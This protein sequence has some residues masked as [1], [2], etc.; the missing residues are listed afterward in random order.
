[1]NKPLILFL[2]LII[3]F[4]CNTKQDN[5]VSNT[6]A[7]V[8]QDT[9][10]PMQS[11]ILADLPDSLQPKTIYLDKMPAPKV[12]QAGKAETKPLAVLQN[13]KG[14]PILD[15][16]GKPFI[17]GEGGK[18][19]F[20]TFTTDNG[21]ALDATSCSVMDKTGNL[22]FGTYG[23]GVSKYNGKSFTNYSTAQG[24]ANNVVFSIL[25]DK[26]GNLWFGTEGGG[27]SKYDGKSFTNYSTAQGLANNLVW[28][29]L[30]DKT[31][32]LWFGTEEGLSVMGG[33][34]DKNLSKKSHNE[35]KRF[36][37]FK[38]ADG[39]PDNFVTQVMQM[40][41]G[42]I[43]VGTNLGIIFLNVNEDF[44]K[45]T[46]IE[47]F[48]SN[49]GYPVKDV[50]VGQNCMYLDS[51]GHIWAG[52]GSEKTAL[53]RFDYAALHK[54]TEPPALVIQSIKVKDENICWYD[55]SE[56]L[57]VK[58]EKL[59][60][61]EGLSTGG[62]VIEE[63]SL[64]K[65]GLT[66]T[67]RAAM[68]NRFGNIQFDGISKF[69]PIPQNLVLPY[70]H[71]QIA[72]DFVAV[73]TD[74]P[75][76][77]KYQYML[78]GYDK[79]WSPVTD[80]SNANFGNINEGTYTFKLKAQGANGVWCEPITYTFQVL[81]PWYRSWWAYLIYL[82]LFLSALRLFIRWR[83]RHL[84]AEKEKLEKTVEERTA[85]VVAEKK[86]ADK[87]REEANKQRKRSDDLLLNIL[88]EEVAE[89]LKAKGSA[90]AK[91]FDEVTVLFTDFKDFTQISEKMTPNEL[92][93]ELNTFFKAFDEIVTRLNI[94]KIKTI[95]DSYMCVGGLPTA[96]P[97]H[98][99]DV[100]NAGLEIQAFVQNHSKYRLAQGKEPLLIRIGIHSGPV[101]AGIVG[102]KKFAYDI[103]GDTVNT[104]SRM[105]SSG[106]AGKVNIS[107]TTYAL[108]KDKF[109]CTHR[110]K[111]QAKGKGKIEM[112]F[113]EGRI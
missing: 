36:T 90:E 100:V 70:E 111:I 7:I 45:L 56:K 18:S 34:E 23:G 1:M 81:P 104:A 113:V 58:S 84:N 94:E 32:N 53:V 19:N 30:E 6:A 93:E 29:I 22:W 64:F 26:T 25:E 75:F 101:I 78:E 106:E 52:T 82:M 38:I 4:S 79:D 13:D 2:S 76:L 39:L 15:S 11:T 33:W 41:N 105:E 102:I 109:T 9:L 74:R 86:E 35:G 89:E 54:Y 37:S 40:P 98:A 80:K 51:K 66:Q 67:E 63:Y 20:T 14:E 110:G 99:E 3:L 8:Q 31:G 65:R 95:G 46:D 59:E 42:K 69:Y 21:L 73:E 71:N 92:V 108:V 97:S 85:E 48:N 96:S 62:N 27:V 88:P 68:V 61:H 24:L 87:Q 16:E 60:G 107:G 49:T 5:Q 17:M 83:V 57:K 103:W 28:C 77:V 112:H 47:I 50:S 44:T 12:A 10:A 72:F 43:A 55:L 91:Q